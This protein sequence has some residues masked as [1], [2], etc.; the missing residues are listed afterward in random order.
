[1]ESNDPIKFKFS[2]K[3]TKIDEILAVDLT[4][5]SR[6][7]ID[8]ED[9][10]I[11]LPFLENMNFKNRKTLHPINFRYIGTEPIFQEIVV[12]EVPYFLD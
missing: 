9:F 3:A 5:C 10:V 6:R 2:K 12:T 4:L 8:N 7:Q 1:M 11:F